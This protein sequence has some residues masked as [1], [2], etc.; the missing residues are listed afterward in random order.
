MPKEVGY[1]FGD[2]MRYPYR[3]V[4]TFSTHDMSTLRGWWRED[5]EKT[6]HFFNDV[7]RHCGNAP[8]DIFPEQCE[9][10]ILG[11]LSCPSMLC[12][13]S[14]QD[15]TSVD[16][17]WRNPDVEQERINVP[18]NPKNYWRYRMHLTLEQLLKADSLNEKIRAL[19]KKERR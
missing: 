16:G 14:F 18:A 7:M 3:S 1:E 19:I 11:L 13:P 17:F 8:S 9:E 2:V 10:V 6:Q 12:V 15:W 4:S 5:R